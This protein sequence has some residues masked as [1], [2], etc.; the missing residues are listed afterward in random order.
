MNMC[1]IVCFL[2]KRRF[3]GTIQIW[4]FLIGCFAVYENHRHQTYS[5]KPKTEQKNNGKYQ[6][7]VKNIPLVKCR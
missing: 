7:L 3:R 6:K 5:N 2:I 4:Q 1:E